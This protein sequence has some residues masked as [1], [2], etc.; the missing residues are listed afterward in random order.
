MTALPRHPKTWGFKFCQSIYSQPMLLRALLLLS[1]APTL[2][3]AD[4][5]PDKV[6]VAV[7]GYHD[8]SKRTPR[9]K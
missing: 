1:L 7:L 5:V 8:F 9:Q 4:P 6:R 3:A 2:P